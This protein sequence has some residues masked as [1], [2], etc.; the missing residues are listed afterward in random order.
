MYHS[1]T[2]VLVRAIIAFGVIGFELRP[3]GTRAQA[4][5]YCSFL[6]ALDPGEPELLFEGKHFF[7][8]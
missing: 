5:F 7:R 8:A 2:F 3:H 6:E 4:L 1:L